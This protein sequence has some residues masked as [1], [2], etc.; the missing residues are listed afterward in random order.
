M[1][2]ASLPALLLA[3][4]SFWSGTF[5]GGAT[6][7]GAVSAHLSVLVFCLLGAAGWRDPLGLGGAGKWLAPLLL[8]AVAA[9]WWLGSV[10][11]AGIV[12]LLLL[13]AFL[14][15]PAA[16][17]SCWPGE[18]ERR[19]GFGA[20]CLLL[21]LVAAFALLRWQ[22]QGSPRAAMP[23]GHHNLLA[24]W[25]VILW[26][27][28]MLPARRRGGWGALA[29]IVGL[30]AAMAL[31][32]SGSFL[33][34]CAL[35]V[36]CL[37]AALWWKRARPW[38]ALAVFL[39]WLGPPIV[40]VS[41]ERLDHTESQAVVPGPE[42][43]PTVPE[44]AEPGLPPSQLERMLSVTGGSDRS[45]QARTVYASAGWRGLH[46][47]PLWGWGPGAVPWT[48]TRLLKPAQ[49]LNP[50][51]EIVGDLHSLPLQLAY[52]IGL[53]GIALSA[54]IAVLFGRRRLAELRR[55]GGA[56]DKVMLQAGCVGLLG[57]VI[58]L[59]GSAPTHVLALPAAVALVAGTALAGGPQPPP[60][61]HRT[62]RAHAVLALL[63][64]LPV[65]F[66][67]VP[68]ERAH[69]HYQQATIAADP[70]IALE[71]VRRASALD[72]G[73]PLYRARAAWLAAEL[74]GAD[75]ATADEALRAAEQAGAVAPL[76]L[77]AGALGLETDRP[78]AG[79]ALECAR[80]LDPLSPLPAFHL[81]RARSG[82]PDAVELGALALNA[83]PL[84]GT[85]LFW[86]EHREL[87]RR[88]LER[89]GRDSVLADRLGSAGGDGPTVLLALSMDRES[90]V[91]FS[92]YGFRRSPWPA[93]LAPVELR[94]ERLP[95]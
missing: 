31:A 47:R 87:Y 90:A 36:Q 2:K 63:Y 14:L 67:L 29:A 91:S 41:L 88:V 66:I 20:L 57:A 25:L 52:E 56:E 55:G 39:V 15:M 12:A 8:L 48:I 95:R 69:R 78:W 75:E 30:L 40:R 49:G 4:L 21:G 62:H 24:G 7:S 58:V 94:V 23:L 17:A 65:A 11:R 82:G 54:A 80:T 59:A 81:L 72:P 16:V 73:F 46:E 22:V 34:S 35:V 42:A 51:S 71:S 83:E 45:K 86:E 64:A 9:S 28:A 6:F 61:T 44:V 50:A 43:S 92:L 13:P 84:L 93:D 89:S 26:P 85:A 77:A 60:K 70:H 68:F 38:L 76:W 27:L 79:E 18:R 5:A 33:A 1:I 3:L 53:I 74:N 37:L 10:H 19:L 32:A